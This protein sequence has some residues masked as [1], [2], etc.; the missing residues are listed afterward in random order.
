MGSKE[1]FIKS[2]LI[3][4]EDFQTLLSRYSWGLDSDGYPKA[5]VDGIHMR[6]HRLVIGKA[7]TGMVIDHINQNKLDNRRSNLRFSTFREN[8]LNSIRIGDGVWY[9]KS[10]YRW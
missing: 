10:K 8:A 7:P 9:N 3:V 1:V 6:L 4:D 5:K 2:E